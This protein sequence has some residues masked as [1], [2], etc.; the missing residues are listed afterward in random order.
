MPDND[1]LDDLISREA[2]GYRADNK[3]PAD[4]MWSRIERDV[5][6]AIRPQVRGAN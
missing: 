5:E 3:A 6:R 1:K 2:K 4:A